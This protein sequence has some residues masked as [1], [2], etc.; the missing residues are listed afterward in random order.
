MSFTNTDRQSELRS[1]SFVKTILAIVVVFYHSILFWNGHWFISTPDRQVAALDLLSKWLNTFHIYGF[2]LVS[3]YLFYFQKH[4]NGKYA[5]LLP[6]VKTKA[7]R[8]L[9]PYLAVSVL[10]AIPFL[11]LLK[12]ADRS[13]VFYNYVLGIS[14]NQLWFL[15]MLFNVF[16]IAWILSSWLQKHDLLA[17]AAAIVLYGIGLIGPRF[18][19]NLF[20][21]WSALKYL[22]FFL[23]GFKIRQH[24]S[25]FLMKIP[26]VLWVAASIGLFAL[27]ISLPD[28]SPMM[29]LL[30]AG[31]S[32]CCSAVGAVMSFVVLQKA[33]QKTHA[34]HCRPL[35]SLGRL[36]MPIYLLHQQLIYIFIVLLKDVLP[37]YLHALVN[38]FG[39]FTASVLLSAL[40]LKFRPTSIL[41]GESRRS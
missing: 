18:C 3:G 36:S 40:L 28:N 26:A 35:A 11:V 22:L 12:G 21:V 20:Q 14:P 19:P 9:V 25:R 7:K 16:I 32:T 33:A 41:L 37:P 4:E 17:F 31:V 27:E 2:T 30:Y 38:F 10:W 5:S 1:C 23:I 15:L 34:E 39:A 13:T 8:L 24:G 29:L 6:F